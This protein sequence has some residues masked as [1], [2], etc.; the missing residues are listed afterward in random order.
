M[1]CVQH[2]RRHIGEHFLAVIG[3]GGVVH[4]IAVD[5]EGAA[6]EAVQE[7]VVGAGVN[8]IEPSLFGG[9]V[10]AECLRGR[11]LG[12]RSVPSQ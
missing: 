6:A 5:V 11:V 12:S 10:L 3:R 7:A 2:C 9:E 1:N 8:H 4:V